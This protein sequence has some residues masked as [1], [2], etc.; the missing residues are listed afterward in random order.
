[1]IHP[2]DTTGSGHGDTSGIE[3]SG[4]KARGSGAGWAWRSFRVLAPRWTILRRIDGSEAGPVVAGC[5]WRWQ[6][7]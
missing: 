7:R 1:M 4:Q 2:K 5:E 3:G 6:R